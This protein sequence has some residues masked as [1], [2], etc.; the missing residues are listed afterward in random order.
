MGVKSDPQK[1]VLDLKNFTVPGPVNKISQNQW[2]LT[3]LRER[4]HGAL[5]PNQPLATISADPPPQPVS[6]SG[7]PITPREDLCAQF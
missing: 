6:H 1:D 2:I 7:K 3:I 4:K 5:A